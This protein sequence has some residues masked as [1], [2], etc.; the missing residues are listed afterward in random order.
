MNV[1]T[2]TSVRAPGER[3]GPASRA[4][5]L[6]EVAGL[7]GEVTRNFRRQ[8]VQLAPGYGSL[9]LVNGPPLAVLREICERPGITVGELARLTGL[10]KSRVSVMLT[11]LAAQRIVGKD[12]D[13]HDS[14]LVR[15]TITAEGLRRAAEWSA[16]SREAID[17]LLEPVSDDEL[18]VI[19]RGLTAL[20]RAFGQ[21]ERQGPVTERRAGALPC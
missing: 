9:L 11:R 21:A 5:V 18:A 8:Q 6:D 10:P 17:R 4:L 2:E 12:S 20:E 3:H 7:L 13:E 16:A 19:A 14:R 15:L 1:P